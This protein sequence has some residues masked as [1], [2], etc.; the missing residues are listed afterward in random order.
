LN[1]L[2]VV[3]ANSNRLWY[4]PAAS[5]EECAQLCADR[6]K[7]R[8][9]T[10]DKNRK[11]CTAY[12]EDVNAKFALDE[13]FSTYGRWTETATRYPG[14]TIT[15]TDLTYDGQPLADWLKIQWSEPICTQICHVHPK[16][17]LAL[18]NTKTNKCA[19]KTHS[20]QVSTTPNPNVVATVLEDD[21]DSR[22]PSPNRG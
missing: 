15:G 7:C 2:K 18:W 5:K 19:L 10:F 4:K 14:Q 16:C 1:G 9:S 21:N 3:T 22:S 13:D 12:A 20:T 17:D 11:V 8:L 6:A